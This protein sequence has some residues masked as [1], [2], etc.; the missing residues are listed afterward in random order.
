[1]DPLSIPNTLNDITPQWLTEALCSTGT[2]PNVVVTSL[3]IEPI[4]EFTCAGQLARLHLSFNQPQSTLPSTLVAKLHAP[5]EPLRAKTRPFT[6]DKCEIL[7]YQHLADEIHL[8][9][10]YCYYSAMN[11]TDGKYVRIFEDLT[12]AKVGDQIRGSTAEETALALRAI[13]GFHAHWWQS[14][15]LEGFDWLAGLPTDSDSINRWILD[16]YRNAFPIFVSKVGVLLTDV[17]KAFGEQLPEKLTDKSQFR[18][19]PRTLVHG[20][21]RLENVFFGPSLGKQ[22]FAVID[23]QD[24]SRGEGVWD[25]AWFIGGCLQV[26]SNRQV[27]EQQLLK[28]YHETLKANGVNGYTFEVCW[29]DYRLAMSRYFVQA[30]LMVASLNSE[31]DREHRLAQAVAERFIAAITDLRL[32]DG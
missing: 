27:E 3:C 31:N 1:M 19:P 22:S 30:V 23:W 24:I 8:R 7:F 29:E 6:P 4:A 13:A 18:K 25:V 28:I 32:I 17:A 21:F 12:P 2:L 16:Q 9:T 11:V 10:P 20:D 26:T 15:K 14:E 5:D